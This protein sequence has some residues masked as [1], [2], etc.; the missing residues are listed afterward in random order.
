MK[1]ER[2]LILAVDDETHIL[3]V[4]QLK[5]VHAGYD[6][7]TAEDG[8]EALEMALSQVPDLVITDFQMP[9]AS[10]CSIE[11]AQCTSV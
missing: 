11:S 7:I 9:F 2:P 10:A 5:L 4:V 6:V 8:E 1:R 3:H